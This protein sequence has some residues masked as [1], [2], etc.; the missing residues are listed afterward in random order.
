MFGNKINLGVFPIA[1]QGALSPVL[2]KEIRELLQRYV[3]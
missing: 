2:V 3:I 1:R